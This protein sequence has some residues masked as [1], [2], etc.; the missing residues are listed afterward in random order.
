M[1]DI[2]DLRDTWN[3]MHCELIK[4]GPTIRNELMANWCEEQIIL[5]KKAYYNTENS[6]YTDEA[7]DS[8]E[9][10]LRVI[11]PTSN[12]LKKVGS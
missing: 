5:A 6:L 10:N 7:Y 9:D 4:Q 11:R 12:V 1:I 3:Q 2:K 8:I